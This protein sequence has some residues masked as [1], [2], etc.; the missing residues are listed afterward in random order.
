MQ[1]TWEGTFADIFAYL[2]NQQQWISPLLTPWNTLPS[3][4]LLR[5]LRKSSS[6]WCD[7]PGI[8]REALNRSVFHTIYLSRPR[9]QPLII[10]PWLCVRARDRTADEDTEQIELF[11]ITA[12]PNTGMPAIILPTLGMA[13]GK[14]DSSLCSAIL[15]DFYPPPLLYSYYLL[16]FF[17]F[18]DGSRIIFPRCIHGGHGDEKKLWGS[19][20]EGELGGEARAADM[21]IARDKHFSA[22]VI[23]GE[24]MTSLACWL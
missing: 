15:L 23:L 11:V 7:L 16:F 8:S 4:L 14:W 20:A 9:L 24:A 18:L 1:T 10:I 13:G 17:F 21:L 2:Q 19:R 6:T 5:F 3:H 12:Y 22:A